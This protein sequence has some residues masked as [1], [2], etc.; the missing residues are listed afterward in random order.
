MNILQRYHDM[1]YG[2][3][4]ESRAEADAWLAGRDFSASLFIDGKWK[5]PGRRQEASRPSTPPPARHWRR[6]ARPAPPTSTPRSPPRARRCP[7][8]AR[9]RVTSAPA[10]FMRSRG[11]C[12]AIPGSSRCW[13]HSTTA[14]RSARAAT[15]TCR[16]PSAISC[17]TP[18]GRRPLRTN[19]PVCRAQAWQG[20]SSRG[21]SRC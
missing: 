11:P 7:P 8:G 9:R 13:N 18:G 19:I 21:I 14:S 16:S 2:P 20:R 10:C 5:K 3:A 4:P 6:S 15:S 1:D 17:I 12:S